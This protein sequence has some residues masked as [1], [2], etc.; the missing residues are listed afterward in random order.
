MG[1]DRFDI[2]GPAGLDGSRMSSA[3]ER[4]PGLRAPVDEESPGR[5]RQA[6]KPSFRPAMRAAARRFW[7]R[8]T[9]AD[10][11]GK[12]TLSGYSWRVSIVATAL[13]WP[14]PMLLAHLCSRLMLRFVDDVGT[15][16][17]VVK[18]ERFISFGGGLLLWMIGFFCAMEA[19][20]AT[21]SREIAA[22][23]FAFGI[24]VI[25]TVC[26]VGAFFL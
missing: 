16:V 11:R 18:G 4:S 15:A 23:R 5:H 25:A 14:L 24:A 26:Y 6:A 1:A 19:L 13:V 22:G 8:V 10:R 20:K 21:D 2:A 9:R 7:D 3:A 17:L 12:P